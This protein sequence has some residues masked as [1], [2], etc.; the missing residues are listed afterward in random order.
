MRE[1]GSEGD[2]DDFTGRAGGAAV[3]AAGGVRPLLIDA[4]R[5]R[6]ILL[7]APKQNSGRREGAQGGRDMAG[8]HDAMAASSA[9]PPP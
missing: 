5:V 4:V 1:G 9:A 2:D 6:G 8:W 3:A 7:A